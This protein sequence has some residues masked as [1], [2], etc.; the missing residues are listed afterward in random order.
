MQD[1]LK[2]PSPVIPSWSFSGDSPGTSALLAALYK[3]K[4]DL[5]S[6][7]KL[8]TIPDCFAPISGSTT[9]DL[10]ASCKAASASLQVH[11]GLNLLATVL[12]SS[13]RFESNT[14]LEKVQ[15]FNANAAAFARSLCDAAG[16]GTVTKLHQ[17]AKLTSF[18]RNTAL[19]G[20]QPLPVVSI[21]RD[22]PLFHEDPYLFPDATLRAADC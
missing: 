19:K 21:L 1:P 9:S 7:S 15:L 20:M 16:P 5:G 2:V 8:P 12:E 4:Q 10:L 14:S 13:V 18:A 11:E 3:G 22:S 17:V 6:L